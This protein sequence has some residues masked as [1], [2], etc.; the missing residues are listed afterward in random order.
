MPL[1]IVTGLFGLLFFVGALLFGDHDVGHDHDFDGSHD[2]SGPSVFSVFNVS[3]FLIGFGG[4]G[5][6]IRANGVGMPGSTM[7]GLATGILCWGI[8]FYVMHLLIKQQGD[9]TVTAVRIMNATGTV[10]L[11]IPA[12]GMGKVQCSVAGSLQEFLARSAKSVP[13]SEGSRV[14]IV[15]D[16]GGVY[17]VEA[18]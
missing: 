14:R 11:P 15:G 18:L 10:V 8:A 3:W 17:L 2:H 9:S 1:F 12:N 16:V 13:L 6:I 5:A 7:S 4:V